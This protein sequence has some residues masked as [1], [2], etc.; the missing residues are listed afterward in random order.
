MALSQDKLEAV[1]TYGKTLVLDFHT[2]CGEACLD[3]LQ[4]EILMN[5]MSIWRFTLATA[6]A[7]VCLLIRKIQN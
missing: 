2:M 4:T 6:V 3:V 5:V 7:S 1:D